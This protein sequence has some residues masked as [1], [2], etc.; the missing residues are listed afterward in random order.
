MS[1]PSSLTDSSCVASVTGKT[2]LDYAE[3]QPNLYKM[4]HLKQNLTTT[5]GIAKGFEIYQTS[6]RCIGEGELYLLPLVSERDFAA[7][8][9]VLFDETAHPGEQFELKPP[10]VVGESNH[11]PIYGVS[12]SQYIT[13]L[14]DVRVRGRSS[15]IIASRHL[16]LDYQDDEP[17]RLDDELEWDPVI[18]NVE[19]G[20]A[21]VIPPR[22]D[23]M[24]LEVEEAFS[25]LGA[26]SDF[27][28]HWMLEYLPRYISAVLTR[29]IPSSVSIL[30]DA[31][32]P[33]PHR[34]SL[35]L[36]FGNELSIIEVPAFVE[37]RVKRLWCAPN[38]MYMPMHE[39][40]NERFSWEAIVASPKRFAPVIQ[41]MVR[42]ADHALQTPEQ[43]SRR[44][45]LARKSFR[46]RKLINHEQI[47]GE[48]RNHG[49][50]IVYPED[51]TFAEQ[52]GLVRNAQYIVATEGSAIFLA[53]FAIPGTRLCILS[54]PLTDPLAIYNS[55]IGMHG[56]EFEVLTGPMVKENR[57]TP[58][59]SDYEISTCDFESLLDGWFA[60]G[61]GHNLS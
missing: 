39:K 14:A 27:F 55:I 34:Q 57:Q 48:A 3:G 25:L 51:Y 23:S 40:R 36:L 5:Y 28:G 7:S 46:H 45:F 17:T 31:H 60:S 47:E 26:R 6:L 22:D 10:K 54:H 49:F 19:N 33:T 61:T 42:R 16:L 29:K 59:D 56:I 11:R 53:Y 13:C 24:P 50:R 18:F 30:I 44:I 41:E 15:A 37:V 1:Q 32:M 4:M 21:W 35:E 52:V 9:G 38:L 12:R 58:H 2:E 20:H 8:Q 43:P